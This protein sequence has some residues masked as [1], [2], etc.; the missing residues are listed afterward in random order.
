MQST[1]AFVCSIRA[2]LAAGA[3]A[4]KRGQGREADEAEARAHQ[5]GAE[6]EK[7]GGAGAEVKSAI[8]DRGV[9]LTA[10]PHGQLRLNR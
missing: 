7:E 5:G 6:A 1:D 2:E 8:T 9:R 10:A 4:T 3:K